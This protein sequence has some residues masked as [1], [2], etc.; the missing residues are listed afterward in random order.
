M[1]LL[2]EERLSNI[3]NEGEEE[4]KTLSNNNATAE[5]PVQQQ[6]S[7]HC[8]HCQ[9]S[10]PYD[11]SV[12]DEDSVSDG[13][14][15]RTIEYMIKDFENT[16][17][18]YMLEEYGSLNVS[19]NTENVQVDSEKVSLRKEVAALTSLAWRQK[20]LSIYLKQ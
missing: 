16:M 20:G 11:N 19:E 3:E 7:V 8:V 9:F 10:P 15:D 4:E 17:I 18:E 2:E 14:T 5:S 1:K 12:P 13:E 6:D